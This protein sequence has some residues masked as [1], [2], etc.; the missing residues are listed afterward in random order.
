MCP[1]SAGRSSYLLSITT[2]YTLGDS[3]FYYDTI[4][5]TAP[6]SALK[7]PAYLVS[8]PS[9]RAILSWSIY[10]LQSTF[11]P[12]CH[13]PISL[14]VAIA[15]D[16]DFGTLFCGESSSLIFLDSRSTPNGSFSGFLTDR[17]VMQTIVKDFA[18]LE[19]LSGPTR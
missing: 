17:C 6:P 3:A 7:F 1:F 4:L 14:V 10:R 11:Y 5:D 8:V 13:G 12:V 9:T 2:Q 18:G 15:G 19:L 16:D